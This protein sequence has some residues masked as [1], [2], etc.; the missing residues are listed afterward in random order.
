MPTKSVLVVLISVL[1]LVSCGGSQSV[2]KKKDLKNETLKAIVKN[3]NKSTPR[4]KTMR[5]RIKGVY[6]DGNQ[7]Q[8]INIS[9][10]FQKDKILWMSAK[11]AGLIQVAKIIITPQKIKFYERINNSY[12]DGNFE[13]VSAFL[14]LELNYEQLQNLFT[15]QALKN[16][17]ISN[18]DFQTAGDYFQILTTYDNG[19][20]QHLLLDAK[21]F[22]IRQQSLNINNKQIKI[23][24]KSYQIIDGFSFPEE[25]VILA[26]DNKEHIQ[27]TMTYKNIKLNDELKFPFSFPNNYSPIQLN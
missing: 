27:I 13:L 14:G 19:F 2:L 4:F 3:Y 5:G 23:I 8:N 16:I 26:G 12:F 24:Y 21:T 7:Q 6:D 9:Y 20:T 25:F 15:G 1:I 10:R 11:F 22:K 17:E 18:T